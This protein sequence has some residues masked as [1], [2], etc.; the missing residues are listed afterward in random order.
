MQTFYLCRTKNHAFWPDDWSR[1]PS[2]FWI[3]KSP[4]VLLVRIIFTRKMYF[5]FWNSIV[6][7]EK[8]TFIET[9]FLHGL[10]SRKNAL[11]FPW[12]ATKFIDILDIGQVV[13]IS[14]PPKISKNFQDLKAIFLTCPWRMATRIPP[15]RYLSAAV[16]LIFLRR[17]NT[18]L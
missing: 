10:Q 11:I 16:D 2:L 18:Y 15:P 3:K 7:K 6:N 1:L 12:L 8:S 14:P 5:L 9:V 17:S 4:I 13:N